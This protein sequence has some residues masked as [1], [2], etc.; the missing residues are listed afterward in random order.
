MSRSASSSVSA[1]TLSPGASPVAAAD[2]RS[3]AS[4]SSTSEGSKAVP[5]QDGDRRALGARR[6]VRPGDLQRAVAV[7]DGQDA[8][9]DRNVRAAQPGGIAQAIP[10]LVMAE[11]EL[12]DRRA[13]R[14]VA[15]DL[16]AH[17]R[18]NL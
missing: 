1:Q 10:P 16:G 2:M 3:R 18:M 6:P 11:H 7:G 8:S 9:A 17:T 15:Q 13:E 4:N 12:A 5:A 14:H